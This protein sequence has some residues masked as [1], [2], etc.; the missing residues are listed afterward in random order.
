MNKELLTEI[1]IESCPSDVWRILVDFDSYSEWN[2][3]IIRASGDAIESNSISITA[4]PK[5][6]KPMDFEPVLVVV[7]EERELRWVG[8]FLFN[9]LFR[10]EH[11]FIIEETEDGTNL[12][13]GEKFSGILVRFMS[14]N[15]D[16][17]T[18]PGFHNL[19]A[20]LKERAETRNPVH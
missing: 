18:L 4:K 17:Q 15:L 7:D 11:F 12:I 2:P 13:H 19:N 1:R 20:A 9:F 3:F 5:G 10:G 16:T 8:K 14:K 6:G